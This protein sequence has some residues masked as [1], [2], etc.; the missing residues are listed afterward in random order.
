M[1]IIKFARIP[2]RSMIYLF[3]FM[4]IASGGFFLAV[5]PSLKSLNVLD[6]KIAKM[7]DRVEAQITL[8]P[9]YQ[10]LVKKEKIYV[11]DKLPLPKKE[12][13]P[14]NKIGTISTKFTEIAKK[15]GFEIIAVNLVMKSLAGNSRFVMVNMHIKGDFFNFRKFLIELGKIEYMEKIEEIEIKQEGTDREFKMKIWLSVS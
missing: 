10:K 13:L 8:L 6:G 9:V 7:R 1:K 12:K 14:K 5:Y 3:I 15:F 2:A 11:P 4:M